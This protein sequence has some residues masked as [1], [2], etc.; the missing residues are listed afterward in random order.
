MHVALGVNRRQVV[1]LLFHAQHRQ[2]GH[3]QDLGLTTL[4]EGGAVHAAHPRDAVETALSWFV[5]GTLAERSRRALVFASLYTGATQR[6][7]Q[8]V[9]GIWAQETSKMS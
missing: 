8:F 4:E 5:D 2:R 3:A 7:M 9:R 1:D 6:Q